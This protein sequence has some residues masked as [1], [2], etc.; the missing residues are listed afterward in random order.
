MHVMKRKVHLEFDEPGD[1]I[2]APDTIDIPYRLVPLTCGNSQKGDHIDSADIR[3]MQRREDGRRRGRGNTS[4]AGRRRN[5]A[6]T[7]GRPN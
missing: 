2:A 7:Y 6:I 5:N 3:V 4:Y 1:A